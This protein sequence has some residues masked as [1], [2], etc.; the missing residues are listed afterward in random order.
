MTERSGRD[1]SLAQFQEATWLC[2]SMCQAHHSSIRGRKTLE[3][4]DTRKYL[5]YNTIISSISQI[6]DKLSSAETTIRNADSFKDGSMV[7]PEVFYSPLPSPMTS[8]L[9]HSKKYWFTRR[10]SLVYFVA[11]T[12][13]TAFTTAQ[14]KRAYS[15]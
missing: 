7:A 1:V 12:F 3:L 6:S 4:M 13:I 11:A 9:P 5:K 2:S 15:Y 8:A 14:Q 10:S